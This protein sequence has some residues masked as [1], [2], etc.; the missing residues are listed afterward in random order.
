MQVLAERDLWLAV[1]MQA[2]ED[3]LTESTDSLIYGEAHSFF[4]ARTL[5]WVQRREEIADCLDLHSDDLT[6]LGRATLAARAAQPQLVSPSTAEITTVTPA[7]NALAHLMP[8][9]PS[10]VRNRAWHVA[11]FE[12]AQKSAA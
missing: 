11:R 8:R 12:A 5:A 3:L 2:R 9:A 10:V 1:V 6:R 7:A 4:L